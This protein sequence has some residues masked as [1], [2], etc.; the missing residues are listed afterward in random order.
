[1][2]A[3]GATNTSSLSK[4]QVKK[5]LNKRPIRFQASHN[6][7]S[8]ATLKAGLNHMKPPM[9]AQNLAS[10]MFQQPQQPQQLMHQNFDNSNFQQQQQTNKFQ[11]QAT[12]KATP[13][14]Y[15]NQQLSNISKR[16]GPDDR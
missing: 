2:V 1:M 7:P 16:K 11:N 14:Q 12:Y 3:A 6:P 10:N 13:L 9:G 4:N 15:N 8:L 5:G